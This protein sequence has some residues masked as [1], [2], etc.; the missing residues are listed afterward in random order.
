M[1]FQIRTYLWIIPILL[2]CA[3]QG[4]ASG[5]PPD[6][7]GPA[8]I[9][10]LP[11]SGTINIPLD[12][13]ITLVFNEMLDP[14]SVPSSVNT[15]LEEGKYHLKVRGRKIYISPKSQWPPDKVIRF[16]LSR[17]IRDY[18]KNM[19]AAPVEVILSTGATIPE[20]E[21]LGRLKNYTTDDLVE[22]GIFIWPITDSSRI[23]QRIEVNED[24][25][26]HFQNIPHGRYVVAAIEGGISMVEK[27]IQTK[28]YAL[29]SV[30]YIHLHSNNPSDSIQIY[31]SNPVEKLKITSIEMVSQHSVK[32]LMNDNSD[33]VYILD[34][35]LT[36]ED[37]VTIHLSK[38]NRLEH[39]S[40]PEYSFILP[41]VTDTLP[42]AFVTSV[43]EDDLFQI[44]FNEPV[45]LSPLA[46][47]TRV[48]TLQVP[49]QFTQM[50]EIT[51]IFPNLAD[52]I[53][54]IQLTG[55]HIFDWAGNQFKD[56][57]KTVSV[58]YPPKPEPIVG[59]NILGKIDY[60]GEHPIMVEALHLEK[61]TSYFAESKKG[62]YTLPNIPAGHYKIWAFEELNELDSTV[63]FSGLWNPF[64]RAA[65]FTEYP[66]TVD[67]RARWDVEG[68]NL[69]IE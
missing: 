38:P 41:S 43:F 34:S 23:Y 26:F 54:E 12:Q 56:S 25:N 24:G 37:S 4:P 65:K 16:S 11:K 61:Q 17:K 39:Y 48:D 3:A 55:A 29:S 18:Q 30:E 66:D 67:V 1:K 7:E 40:L 62:R 59:G 9:S 28:K 32:L 63:Y 68:I 22:T 52:T 13:K 20:G 64:K 19:M 15:T 53:S 46:V 5:G 57:V 36:P 33:E 21:I 8:V 35:L 45:H 47:T 69:K 49:V 50:D 14:V 2:G 42:P 27:Q 60:S 10:I 51:I 58:F 44:V 6:S 31:Y